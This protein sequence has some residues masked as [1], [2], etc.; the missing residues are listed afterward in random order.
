MSCGLLEAIWVQI[1]HSLKYA[2]APRCLFSIR[3]RQ[4][5]GKTRVCRGK[6]WEH[7]WVSFCLLSGGKKTDLILF[8]T[9]Y[10]KNLAERKKLKNP[11][12]DANS[13]LRLNTNLQPDY[14]SKKWLCLCNLFSTI[15]IVISWLGQYFT[16]G[17]RQIHEH[18]V[19]TVIYN[20]Y[21]C[22]NC[23]EQKQWSIRY[24]T[25]NRGMD[26]SCWQRWWWLSD[27]DDVRRWIRD[28]LWSLRRWREST[29]GGGFRQ[30]SGSNHQLLEVVYLLH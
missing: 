24:P 2:G 30:T 20:C 22:Y 26:E 10:Q 21:N 5:I 1:H 12:V 18:L 11:I 25:M 7:P 6:D 23:P 19:I 8:N 13:K 4:M 29:P 17:R 27:M 3:P 15:S 14:P 9:R 28:G 16:M